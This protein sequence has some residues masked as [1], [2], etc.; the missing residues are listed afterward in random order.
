[1]PTE[2]VDPVTMVIVSDLHCNVGM[3][4]VIGAVV[5]LAQAD[6]L[7]NA[8]DTVMAGTSVEAACINAFADG[9]PNGIPVVVANGNHDSDTTAD[10]EAARGW[11]VLRGEPIEVAGVR[12]LG[13]TDPT[14]SSLGAPTS[15]Q[16]GESVAQMGQRLGEVACG[17]QATAGIDLMLVHNPAAA[18]PALQAGCVPM[19]ISGHKHR[20][21]GPWQRGLGIEYVSASTAGAAESSPTIGPLL[22]PATITVMRWDRANHLPMDFRIVTLGVDHSVDLGPWQAFP[23]PPS[24]PVDLPVPEPGQA[25]WD[26]S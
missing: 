25:P 9:V 7:L 21:V 10:Q 13:D 4:P 14:L 22:A 11:Q 17:A 2:P 15:G 19:S 23:P 5:E 24:E 1:E 8:G 26:Q 3:A 12:I 6:M 16:R 18:T 20:Q